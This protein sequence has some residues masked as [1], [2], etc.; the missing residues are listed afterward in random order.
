MPLRNKPKTIHL[1]KRVSGLDLLRYF[2]LLCVIATHFFDVLHN[3]GYPVQRPFWVER[4]VELAIAYF[5]MSSAFLITML[6]LEEYRLKGKFSLRKFLYR[7]G[8]RLLPAYLALVLIVYLVVYQMPYFYL[9][10]HPAEYYF[11][12]HRSLFNFLFLVPHINEFFYPSAPYLFHT[13]TMGIEYQFYLVAGLLFFMARKRY[14]VL[15]LLLFIL[16][17]MLIVLHNLSPGLFKNNGLG[18]LNSLGVYLAYTQ[19]HLF[20]AGVFMAFIYD[21]F[22]EKMLNRVYG[23]ISFVLFAAAFAGYLFLGKSEWNIISGG[24]VIFTL[25]LF[26]ICNQSLLVRFPYARVTQWLGNISYGAYLFHYIV[27][28]VVLK[29][30]SALLD[31]NILLNR[32]SALLC[33]FIAC[34]F[35]GMLSYYFIERSFLKIK[36]KYTTI[37]DADQLK[38]SSR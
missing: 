19:I 7:R 27:M 36:K 11:N 9:N 38:L 25:L 30:M 3:L 26:V 14:L 12:I 35:F 2:S 34:T 31:M 18:M 28:V 22:K 6:F 21:R 24:V 37:P 8:L 20:A 23:S 10:D 4:L 17:I 1:N 13:T 32:L 15:W 33:V 16:T 29:I 5:F